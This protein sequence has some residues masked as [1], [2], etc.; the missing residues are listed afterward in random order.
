MEARRIASDRELRAIAADGVGF[1]IAPFN[2]RWH[3]AICPHVLA[4][5]VNE[6]KWFA[7]T[8]A[9][10]TAFL[11]ERMVKYEAAKPIEACPACA[12]GAAED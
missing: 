3:A 5:T 4:M 8:L 1:V 2:Q 10:L 9:S 6:P 12:N 7:A 11:Q